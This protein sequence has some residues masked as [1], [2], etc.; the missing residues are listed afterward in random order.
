MSDRFRIS[1]TSPIG[2]IAP[3][4]LEYPRGFDDHLKGMC[5]ASFDDAVAAFIEAADRRCI[6]CDKGAV[7]DT[8]WGWECE[9][10]GSYD[11]AS[12]HERPAVVA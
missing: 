9:A 10:C 5:C 11:V 8:D 7:V 3:W 6:T 12:G 1:K 2:S 4:Y